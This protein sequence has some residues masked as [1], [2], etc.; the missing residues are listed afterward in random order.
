M[1][2]RFSQMTHDLMR[3]AIATRDPADQPDALALETFSAR[4]RDIM[5]RIRRLTADRAGIRN[6][7]G[8]ET[9]AIGRGPAD[10]DA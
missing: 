1:A 8:R 9:K 6:G 10:Y 3:V 2:D 4:A 5:G 7:R